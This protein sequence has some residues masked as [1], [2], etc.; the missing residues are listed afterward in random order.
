MYPKATIVTAEKLTAGTVVS[1]A[2][3]LK[4]APKK[5]LILTPEAKPVK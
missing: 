4:G 1:Y 5:E 3:I 2:L